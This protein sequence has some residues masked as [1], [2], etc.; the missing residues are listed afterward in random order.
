MF[1]GVNGFNI[2]HPDSL[3]E[4]SQEFPIAFTDFQIFN[5]PVP[6]GKEGSPLK[7]HINETSE[8][9]LPYRHSVFS[10][11]YAALSF[12]SPENV[13]YKYSLKGFVNEDWQEVGMERKVTYTNLHPGTYTFQVKASNVDGLWDHKG[14][15]LVI[16]ILSPW[17]KTWWFRTTAG[18][19]IV[20]L[21]VGY[22]KMRVHTIKIQNKKLESLVK[23]RTEELQ[24]TNEELL[25]RDDEIL[26]QNNE[27]LNQ[28][29]ALASQNEELHMARHTIEKQNAE[30]RLQNETL[31]EEV[32]ERTK[33]LVE[34]NQQLEQFAFISAH[35][36]R[37]PVARILG[38]GNLL[39]LIKSEPS[40]EYK[41]VKQ[42]VFSTR[43]LDTVI[44]DL[45]TILALRKDNISIL[46]DVN[47][48]EELR[49][50]KMNLEKE[51][52]ETEALINED[53]SRAPVIR[54]IKP[55]LDSILINLISNAI[56]YRHG[57]RC[58]VIQIKSEIVENYICLTVDDNGLGINLELF[59][60][61]LFTLYSRFHNHVDGKGMGLYLVK[62]Q[63]ASLGGRIEV[64][65]EIDRGT[66]FKIFFRD[67]AQ[68]LNKTT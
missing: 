56:K 47:L 16:H 17:W 45:N 22:Y 29:E 49:L 51:I 7:E 4:N 67:S 14:A 57:A 55:Y 27:L 39:E 65:S 2:F 23:N 19:L 40:E 59:Q 33:E 15:S 61:K 58:P 12:L 1:G 48:V 41:I 53:F 37:A 34:Y 8:V 5:K 13:R 3:V 25:E 66:T 30:I 6:I 20:G 46:T 54:T 64:E 50:V 36:L 35:N 10:L 11:E 63:V 21:A 62:T 52:F 42:L 18:L 9:T 68:S 43:E 24:Q 32:K 60:E 26:A 38:L 31:E 44:K 28:R